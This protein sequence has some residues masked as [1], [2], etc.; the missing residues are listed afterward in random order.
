MNVCLFSYYSSSPLPLLLYLDHISSVFDTMSLYR[1]CF[2][3]L[4]Q[5]HFALLPLQSY[6][7]SV[8]PLFLGS[9]T[10]SSVAL[11]PYYNLICI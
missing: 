10:I 5:S 7:E 11:L 4:P 2:L 8:P 3:G 6:N 9:T 1:R